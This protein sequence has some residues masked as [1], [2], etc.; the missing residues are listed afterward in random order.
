MVATRLLEYVRFPSFDGILVDTFLDLVIR[1]DASIIFILF[2]LFTCSLI[3]FGKSEFGALLC[4][5]NDMVETCVLRTAC[6]LISIWV[7]AKGEKSS[8]LQY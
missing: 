8:Q 2:F 5:F 1:S 4:R 6:V 7:S 3:P